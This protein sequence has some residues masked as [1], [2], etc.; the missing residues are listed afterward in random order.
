MNPVIK[1]PATG[2]GLAVSDVRYKT[3]VRSTHE[4]VSDQ[5][6]VP[7][8]LSL[9]RRPFWPVENLT[10]VRNPPLFELPLLS[11]D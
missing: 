1:P 7:Q 4:Y 6:A 9:V 5:E 10:L 8:E 3:R 2:Q 11:S